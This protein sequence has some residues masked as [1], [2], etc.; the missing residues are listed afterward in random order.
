MPLTPRQQDRARFDGGKA[1]GNK[2]RQY[3]QM[4]TTLR[5]LIDSADRDNDQV[6]ILN[7][8]EIERLRQ[9]LPVIDRVVANFA[10]DN[11][12]AKRIKADYDA[13]CKA[14][15]SA[16]HDLV[17]DKIADTIALFA[18][19]HPRDNATLND[20][21]IEVNAAGYRA[22]QMDQMLRDA[23]SELTYRMAGQDSPANVQC[24]AIA[25]QL[26][27]ARETH[28]TLIAHVRAAAVARR[29]QETA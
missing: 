25:P 8:A 28:S 6:G 13:R 11:A 10:R 5:G 20:L 22:W 26:A 2:K 29:L 24:A 16:L 12:A 21:R 4:A 3:A 1:L 18:V 17:H 15:S 23:V 19:A 7:P 14:I 9:A 27:T